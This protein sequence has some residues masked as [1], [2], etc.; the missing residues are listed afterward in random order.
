MVSATLSKSFLVVTE[1]VE[2]LCQ[3]LKNSPKKQT[4]KFFTGQMPSVLLSLKNI[5]KMQYTAK[6]ARKILL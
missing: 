5:T 1:I 3:V 6:A 4:V 2:M